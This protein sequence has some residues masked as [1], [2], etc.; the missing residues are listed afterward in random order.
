VQ[1]L[2][3]ETHSFCVACESAGKSVPC[4]HLLHRTTSRV[5]YHHILSAALPGLRHGR[6]QGSATAAEEGMPE[7][8]SAASPPP[9][10]P[11]APAPPP[12]NHTHT[13]HHHPPQ[14]LHQ[15]AVHHPRGMH[16]LRAASLGFEATC[17]PDMAN[18]AGGGGRVEVAA[19]RRAQGEAESP[20][21]QGATVPSSVNFSQFPLMGSTFQQEEG[22]RLMSKQLASRVGNT[23]SCGSSTVTLLR[24]GQHTPLRPRKSLY[25]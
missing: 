1:H 5:M 23:C 17:V 7:G 14:L 8:W 2:G 6:A 12:P 4:W 13:H 24:A 10:P 3:V 18:A 15:S 9:S 19:S 11:P 20:S 25:L 21:V 16:A 22:C